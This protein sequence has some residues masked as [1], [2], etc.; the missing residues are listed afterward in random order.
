MS[1]DYIDYSDLFCELFDGIDLTEFRAHG[2]SWLLD[3]QVQSAAAAV[4]AAALAAEP[5]DVRHPFAALLGLDA[6]LARANPLLGGPA[7]PA[8]SEY[9][10]RYAESGRFDSG[11]KPGALLPR[12]ARPGRRGQLPQDLADTFGALVR[13]RGADWD[14]C[15]HAT[16]PPHARLT[17][18]DREAGLRVATAPMI[19]DPNELEWEVEERGGVRFYRIHPADHEATRHRVERVI[20]GW[21]K[22]DVAIGMVPELCLSPALLQSWQSALRERERAATSKLRMVVAGSGN[23]EETTPPVNSAV[24]LDARTGEALARQRKVHPFNFSQADLELWGLDGRLSAPIDEDLTRGERV[25]VVET[26]GARL[27]VLVCE[28]LARL[29]AFA[30]ALHGHGVSLILV[31][32]FARPTKDRRWERSRAEVYSDAIGSSVVVANSLVMASILRTP[33]PVGTAIAV[34]PGEAAVGHAAA[35]DDVVVFTLEG[36]APRVAHEQSG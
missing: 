8:L 16:L 32:V 3:P 5:I 12:F 9:A 2:E 36:G 11:G 28:D 21:D 27:A 6:A 31:P 17:R 10:L 33:P 29:H 30:A 25:C 1:S 35:P 20:A 7:P 34:A 15:D 13:V 4:E 22:R 14:A 24:L 18:L 23:V 19:R 26:G